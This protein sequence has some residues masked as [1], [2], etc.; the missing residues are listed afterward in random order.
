MAAVDPKATLSFVCNPTRNRIYL[1]EIMRLGNLLVL[2]G[3]SFSVSCTPPTPSS[4]VHESAVDYEIESAAKAGI[5]RIVTGHDSDGKAIFASDERVEPI[6]LALLPGAK[7]YRIWGADVPPSFPD[8]GSAQP[9][10]TYFPLL[11]G[12]RFG[13]FTVAPD[14][15]SEIDNLDM[16]AALAEIEVKLPGATQYLEP[17]HPGMHTTASIDYEYVVSGRCVLE[18]DDGATR[19]L[20]P[21]DTVVQNG[22]RHA[23]RNPF[24]EPCV[25]VVVL[26]GVPNEL[27]AASDE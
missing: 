22:T 6:T 12:Y 16:E 9:H 3:I 8:D 27:V 19:E 23:W 10:H 21:G 11:G 15:V 13:L 7:F 2:I 1:G 18:L 14:S 25:M 5:R 24:D 20:G 17:D 4:E 26:I